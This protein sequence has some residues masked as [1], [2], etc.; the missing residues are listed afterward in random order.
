MKTS[1][2]DG[3][4]DSVEDGRCVESP[5]SVLEHTR[6]PIECYRDPI[7]IHPREN[8]MHGLQCP[9]HHVW[10]AGRFEDNETTN[11]ITAI[12]RMVKAHTGVR[13]DLCRPTK[14]RMKSES[15][16]EFL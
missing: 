5:M 16:T 2:N 11:H 13:E 8:R 10:S 9:V 4:N 14:A 15:C 12:C 6:L 3:A 7:Q 1:L